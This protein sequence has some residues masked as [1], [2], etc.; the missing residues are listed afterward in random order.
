MR[1]SICFIS[2]CTPLGIRQVVFFLRFPRVF[3]DIVMIFVTFLFF[4]RLT[5]HF[6]DL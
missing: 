6:A 3:P 4:V 1:L 2:D 5:L